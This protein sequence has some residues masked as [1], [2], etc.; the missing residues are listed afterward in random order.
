MTTVHYQSDW[1]TSQSGPIHAGEP[2]EISYAAERLP[3]CRASYR[4]QDAWN[5]AAYVR[6]HPGGELVSG[7]VAKKPL[8]VDVPDDATRIE[9]WFNNTD[10][11]GCSVWDSRY[12]QN[13]WLDVEP[14]LVPA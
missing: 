6:F 7:A 8:V 14:A 2:L 1:T 4:G 10:N 5:I 9:L 12:C 11:T 13:Y 3:S